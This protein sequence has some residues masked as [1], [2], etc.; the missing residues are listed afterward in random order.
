VTSFHLRGAETKGGRSGSWG[1]DELIG[2]PTKK[3]PG[4]RMGRPSSGKAST[5]SVGLELRIALASAITVASSLN[6]SECAPMDLQSKFFIER[7]L[8]SQRQPKCGVPGGENFH[9]TV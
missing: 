2:L 9:S 8:A 1:A 5:W 4:V 6:V 7:T 3:W